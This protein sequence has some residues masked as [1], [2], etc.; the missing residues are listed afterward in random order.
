MPPRRGKS[1]DI[2]ARA[3]F[4]AGLGFI[5]PASA[6]GGYFIGRFLDSH[7]H[8][9]SLL[10]V[11]GVFAGTAAGIVEVIQLVM[12]MEK[13]ASQKGSSTEDGRD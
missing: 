7:L 4:Y 12:R 10:A 11:I 9:G 2:W 5:I 1:S 3:A 6:V 13:N 8:T